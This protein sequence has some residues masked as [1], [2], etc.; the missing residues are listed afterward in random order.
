MGLNINSK[1]TEYLMTILKNEEKL[2]ID[3]AE[4]KKVY[5]FKYPGS[6][7]E[8]SGKFYYE[9]EK[10]IHERRKVINILNSVL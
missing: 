2:E 4:I 1:K 6:F 8:S 7:S 3:N 5:I 10:I 9:I